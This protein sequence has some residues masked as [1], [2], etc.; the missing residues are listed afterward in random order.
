MSIKS[1]PTAD[2]NHTSTES[3]RLD[4]RVDRSSIFSLLSCPRNQQR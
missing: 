1:G 3:S 2:V 4:R